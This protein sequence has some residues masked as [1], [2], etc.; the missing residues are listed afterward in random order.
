MKLKAG[1]RLAG[2]CAVAHEELVVV[3]TDKGYAKRVRVDDFPVQAR[4]GSG[5]RAQ[6]VDRTRGK[7][8]GVVS[9]AERVALLT[10]DSAVAFDG[11]SVRLSTR[12]GGGAQVAGVSGEVRRVIAAT[13][14]VDQAG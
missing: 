11:A 6:K 9:A 12:E 3:A 5:L 1:D 10:A 4:G 8:V 7:V 13:A 14:A 2:G